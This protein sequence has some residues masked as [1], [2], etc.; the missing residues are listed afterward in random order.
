MLR[1]FTPSMVALSR[2]TTMCISGLVNFKFASAIW[3]TGLSLTCSIKAGR[4][5]CSFSKFVACN[6]YCIGMPARLP[7]KV[8]CC[9]TKARASVSLRTAAE[10]S[11][12]ISICVRVRL[13]ISGKTIF[14][15]PPVLIDLF[16]TNLA[17][18]A[19]LSTTSSM[20][21]A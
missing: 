1:V 10:M 21:C 20:R 18:G 8:D 14:T 3:N 6:T 17:S 4:N 15:K 12:A 19:T 9:C 5:S 13:L 2:F 16:K 11:S 7:P